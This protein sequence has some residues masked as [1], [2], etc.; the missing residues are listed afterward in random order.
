MTSQNYEKAIEILKERFGRNQVLINAHMESLSKIS[1]PSAD[2][3]QLQNFYD[4]CESNILALE[5][6]GVQT[7]SYGSLLIPI[8][9][10]K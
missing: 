8:L 9:L 1:A 10:K 3:Q 4:S 6:L 7:D 2:V 5:M